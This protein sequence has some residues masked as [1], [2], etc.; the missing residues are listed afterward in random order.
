M[1]DEYRQRYE[2]FSTSLHRTEYEMA[3]GHEPRLSVASLY[4]EQSDL[5]SL[6]SIEELRAALA[7]TSEYRETA[8]AAIRRLITFAEQGR[9]WLD[10]REI[11]AEIDAYHAR[12]RVEWNG[13]QLTLAAVAEALAGEAERAKRAELWARASDL[14]RA[15]QDL[16]IERLRLFQESARA[17]GYKN[18]LSFCA[19]PNRLDEEQFSARMAALLGRTES[20]YASV[21]KPV[22]LRELGIVPEEATA[23]DLPRLRRAE[24]FDRFLVGKQI[25]EIYREIFS[26]L[27]FR[28]DSQQNIEVDLAPSA[29]KRYRLASIPIRVPEE[30]KLLLNPAGDPTDYA[31]LLAGA[32]RAQHFAWT[33]AN[34][35]PELRRPGD[36]ALGAGWATLFVSLVDEPNWLIENFAFV[37]SGEYRH[38]RA[39]LN[40]L[41]ARRDAALSIYQA[42]LYG[43]S[44]SA[45]PG[46]R[47]A[48]LMR[49]AVGVEYGEAGHMSELAPRWAAADRMRARAFVVQFRDHLK[50]RYGS[51]WWR[52]QKAGEM[53]IDLWNT[54]HRYT[55]EELA[56]VIGLGDLDYD[57]LADELISASR[58][59]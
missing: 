21:F 30:V 8:R 13:G 14:W 46:P 23:A 35:P 43:E 31:R 19:E 52:Q 36:G 41:E 44:L 53:I 10:A 9:V 39:V 58:P 55:I 18:Y 29:S 57:F 49:E 17:L 15:S 16:Y 6:T 42:E 26:A 48:E 56:G 20:H 34:I 32:A 54:G 50:T 5:F 59:R 47:Y 4:H 24:R 12:S 28:P 2:D 25:S 37:E 11:S 33:S 3:A 27:G 45:P 22:L 38:L 40:L 51:S 1:L 7:E